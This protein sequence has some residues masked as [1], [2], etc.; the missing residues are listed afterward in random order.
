MIMDINMKSKSI[1]KLIVFVLAIHLAIIS[2]IAPCIKN[3]HPD[4]CF[5][6]LGVFIYTFFLTWLYN[7]A[8]EKK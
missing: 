1:F 6:V 7:D 5:L 3:G 8:Y 2:V 4:Y